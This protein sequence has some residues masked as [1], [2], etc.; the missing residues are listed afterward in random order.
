MPQRSC[1]VMRAAALSN[2]VSG[3]SVGNCAVSALSADS[4]CAANWGSG[5]C[6][7]PSNAV[8]TNCSQSDIGSVAELGAELNEPPFSYRGKRQQRIAVPFAKDLHG[9]AA[10]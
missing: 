4:G 2:A 8:F 9:H 5:A 3:L 10:A 1:V 6:S 7:L